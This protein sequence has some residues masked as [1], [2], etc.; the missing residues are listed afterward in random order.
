MSD[1]DIRSFL[2]LSTIHVPQS[3]AQMLDQTPREEWPL[4]GGH[5]SSYGWFLWCH[6]EDVEGNIPPELM[7]VFDFARSKGCNYVLFD[8]DADQRDDLP[9]FEW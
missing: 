9:Q 1:L 7:V 5:W 2:I 3:V 4:C 6:E 8:C